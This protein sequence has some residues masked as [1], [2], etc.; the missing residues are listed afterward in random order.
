MPAYQDQQ[1]IQQLLSGLNTMQMQAGL[2]PGGIPTYA[3]PSTSLPPPPMHPAQF[4]NSLAL[5]YS[6]RFS[7]IGMPPP[8]FGGVTPVPRNDFANGML[9][10]PM[11]GSGWGMARQ[12]VQGSAN[13]YITGAQTVAGVGG[14]F[15]GGAAGTAIGATIGSLAGPLGTVAGGLIGGYLGGGAGSSLAQLPFQPYID[16]RQRALQLQNASLNN[17]RTGADVSASGLGLGANAAMSLERNLTNMADNR[18]FKRD[19]GNMFNRQDMMKITQIS[20]QVGLL[21]NAQSVD[22]MSKEMGKIGRALATFMKVV[23]EP[24][25]QEALKMMGKMRSMGMNVPEMNVAASNARTFARM[26]GTTV[27]GVMAQGMQGAGVFQQYGMSGAAGFNVG[28]AAVGAAGN[29]ATYMD[30]RQLSMLGGRE[31]VAGS[32][33]SAAAKMTN[34]DALLPGLA[35]MGKDGKLGIDRNA[36]LELAQGKRSVTG[37]INKSAQQLSGMGTKGFVEAYSTQQSE[38]KDELM[39]SLGGQGS[40][41]A[42]MMIARS[43]METGAVDSIGAGLRLAGLDEKEARTVELAARSPEFFQNIRKSN[44]PDSIMRQ[45]ERSRQ[46]QQQRDRAG[47]EVWRRGLR[48]AGNLGL[49]GLRELG[50]NMGGIPGDDNAPG[51]TVD[52][53]ARDFNYIGNTVSNFMQNEFGDDVDLEEQQAAAGGGDFLQVVRSSRYGSSQQIRQLQRQ[54]RTKQGR[55]SITSRLATVNQRVQ[56]A[57]KNEDAEATFQ[58]GIDQGSPLTA[59]ARAGLKSAGFVGAEGFGFSPKSEFLRDTVAR[60]EGYLDRYK[61]NLGFGAELTDEQVQKRAA[62]MQ[63]TGAFI[64]QARGSRY[65]TSITQDMNKR[66]KSAGLQEKTINAAVASASAGINTYLER[67]S[68]TAGGQRLN[69]SKSDMLSQIRE[70]LLNKNHSVETVDKLMA[71]ESF[72]AQALAAGEGSRSETGKDMLN[73]AERGGADI[74][75]AIE[76]RAKRLTREE[77]DKSRKGALSGLGIYGNAATDADKKAV[78]DIFADTGEGADTKKK[79]MVI[80][81]LRAAGKTEQADRLEQELKGKVDSKEFESASAFVEGASQTLDPDTLK[82]VGTKFGKYSGKE[83]YIIEKVTGQAQDASASDAQQALIG[84]LGAKGAEIYSSAPAGERMA[85]LAEYAKGAGASMKGL[86]KEQQK[87]LAAGEMGEDELLQLAAGDLSAGAEAVVAGGGTQKTDSGGLDEVA[88]AMVTSMEEWANKNLAKST[89]SFSKLD[90][91][92]NKLKE[93]AVALGASEDASKLG[94]GISE[95]SGGSWGLPF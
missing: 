75:A 51:A 14:A 72:V 95:A 18:N 74:G 4:S 91:A 54:L 58:A 39:S 87:K 60:N 26:A 8:M 64:E 93:A 20:A 65:D 69:F 85:R 56:R 2:M 24:D 63:S 9:P 25:V 40:V 36:L 7:P 46:R 37:L 12:R 3:P 45:A 82:Q 42:P 47:S 71:D 44:R 5:D 29:M 80:K 89:E 77:A 62:E 70:T 90:E 10:G 73:N 35:T 17:V 22:Q 32:L 43:L 23:E 94:A 21:D 34:L 33:T 79:L 6:S 27:Q 11:L 48:A 15:A 49:R 57:I 53:V 76:G 52:T 19:T 13:A 66:L 55:E 81:A 61:R 67:I 78:M 28:M 84:K 41:L 83:D 92:S 68:G 31:G 88:D 59:M 1:A 86:S 16:Q 50:S 38:L 30:P